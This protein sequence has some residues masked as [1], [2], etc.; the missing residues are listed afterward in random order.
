MLIPIFGFAWRYPL[1]PNAGGLTDI[2]K[3]AEYRALPFAGYVGGIAA[4]FVFYLLA[5]RESRRLAPRQ[6]LPP[7]LGCGAL[8]TVGMSW[9]YPVNAIDV[10]LYAVR[11]RLLTTYGANPNAALP[12]DFPADTWANFMTGEWAT[13]VSPYGPLWN[14]IASPFTALSGDNIIVA[15]VGFKIL[16]SACLLAGGWVIARALLA[17][18][19]PQDAAAGA[20]LYTWNPLVLWEGV[21]N[22]HNDVLLTLLV[23][24][25]LWAWAAR[26]V[27]PETEVSLPALERRRSYVSGLGSASL[28][29]PLLVV[30]ALLKYITLPLIPLAAIALWCTTAGLRARA[31]LFGWSALLSLAAIVVALFPFY[32]PKALWA[33]IADQGSIAVTSP[34]ASALAMLDNY[35]PREQ[36]R[37]WL[38]LIGAGGVLIA[39]AYQAGA[40]SG[41]PERLPCACFEVLFVFLLLAAW[42]LRP[43]YVI[44]LLGLAALC[45]DERRTIEERQNPQPRSTALS[46]AAWRAIA[47]SIGGL[48]SYAFLIWIE[49]WWQPGY[50]LAQLIGTLLMVGP[51]LLL[52][53]A[54]LAARFLRPT[55]KL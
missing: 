7:I 27:K 47:W 35:Y 50:D 1:G 16:M 31:R 52:T 8:M 9:L 36:I 15:L 24:L 19:R 22:A 2:G 37:P 29:I 18:G 34:A 5:L 55:P 41:R 13:H 38:L 4:L 45:I 30:A 20:L 49:A 26:D 11:S 12:R 17:A 44:W 53:L 32:D 28:V 23:L 51:A 14:L 3:L 43:W 39:W 46:W 40:L 10:F 25:A 48:A 42:N 54:R 6:A 33:S 21:G